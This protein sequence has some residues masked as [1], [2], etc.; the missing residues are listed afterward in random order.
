MTYKP[1]AF[2]FL[3]ALFVAVIG[4]FGE[5]FVLLD[6]FLRVGGG[7]LQSSPVQIAMNVLAG[8]VRV[9]TQGASLDVPTGNWYWTATRI[10]PDTINEF[11]FFTFLYADLHAHLM[12]LPFTLV[13]LGCA[14]NFAQII[15]DERNTTRDIK[16]STVYRLWSV[17]LQELPILAITSLVVGALR[18]LNTWDYPTYLAVIVCALAIGEYARRRNIDRYAVFSLAWKFF[19]I[20]VL[21]TLFFQPFIS[22]YATAYTSVELWQS[23]RTTLPE[24]LVVHGIFLFAVATFLV[25]QTFDTRARRGVLRFLRL[26]VAKRARVTRLL[27]LHRA[28]VAYPSLSEDLALIGFAML[29]MLEFLL[30]IAGLTVFALVIPLGVLAAV[31]VLRPEIDPARRLIALLI[32][33]ALAMTLMVEVVTL[34][35][36]IGRMNTVFKFYLQVW[37]FLGVASAAG[38]GV[39]SHQST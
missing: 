4:N 10:I 21:S 1:L 26:I 35:G 15:N 13:A 14:V 33:A 38:I 23:T 17:F 27:F 8:I 25:R 6:A 22:N 39:F 19:V 30:I 12:A 18:P 3:G 28:L 16:S 2:S 7:N 9:V 34:R 37:I 20:V 5:L 11:P 36:D 24:Y 32:G 31:I 29:V